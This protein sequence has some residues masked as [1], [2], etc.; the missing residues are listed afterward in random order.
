MSYKCIWAD[1]VFASILFCVCVSL[2]IL[3]V[4]GDR[5]KYPPLYQLLLVTGNNFYSLNK[6]TALLAEAIKYTDNISEVG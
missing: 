3:M 5:T 1:H 4:N 2:V 6:W